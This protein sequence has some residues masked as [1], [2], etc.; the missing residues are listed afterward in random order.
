M[1]SQGTRIDMD[2]L[3]AEAC[4]LLSRPGRQIM[5]IVGAPGSGKSTLVDAL[6]RR[7]QP[8]H[9]EAVAI[10]PMDGFHYD[11][12][13]LKQKGRLA[14]KGAPDTFDIGGL[15]SALE[16]LARGDAPVAVPV[17]DRALEVSRGSARIIAPQVRLILCEGNYL[18]LDQPPWGD[19]ARW[20]D[21]S[22]MIEVPEAELARRLRARWQGYGLSPA[23]IDRKLEANDLPNGRTVRRDSRA[24]DLVLLQ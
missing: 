23:E 2:A 7:L 10:L 17:F 5:A 3:V 1:P 13:V 19:L 20:F 6:A 11:D 15:A 24:A 8:E 12:A 9:T 14:Q 22:V 18:L 4:A 21:R 16:R